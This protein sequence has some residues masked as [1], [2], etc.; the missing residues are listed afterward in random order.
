MLH[1]SCLLSAV[2]ASG[3]V[4]DGSEWKKWNTEGVDCAHLCFTYSWIM[5]LCV[6][7]WHLNY[8]WFLCHTIVSRTTAIIQYSC[9]SK[10]VTVFWKFTKETNTVTENIPKRGVFLNSAPLLYT[11]HIKCRCG[12]HLRLPDE[13]K[14]GHF[15]A[16]LRTGRTSD[17]P[18]CQGIRHTHSVPP[19][20]TVP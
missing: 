10:T 4:Q 11:I 2:S 6:Q 12:V 20:S 9:H 15:W 8:D 14:V 19:P 5:V 17:Q 7:Y 16:S 1:K 3:T 13:W 18:R